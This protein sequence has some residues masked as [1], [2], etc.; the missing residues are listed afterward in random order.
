M[1]FP[2]K[3]FHGKIKGKDI[4]DFTKGL[5]YN[6]ESTY[7]RILHIKNKLG[8]YELDGAKFYHPFWE[9]IFEQSFDTKLKREGVYYVKE[10]NQFLTTKEFKKWCTK[11]NIEPSD[12]LDLETMFDGLNGGGTWNYSNQNTSKIKLVLNSTDN[13]YSE[14]NIAKGLE[15]I[16]DYILAKDKKLEKVDYEFY[17]GEDLKKL[18]ALDEATIRKFTL[19]TEEDKLLFYKDLAIN[20]KKEKKQVLT[21]KDRETEYLKDYVKAIDGCKHILGVLRKCDLHIKEFGSVQEEYKEI[22]ERWNSNRHNLIKVATGLPVDAKIVKDMINGTIY[23]KNP[24][25]DEGSPDWD[26]VDMTN[27]SHVRA[28]L[29]IKPNN[30]MQ[31][32][33]A[34]IVYDLDML[35][36]K[37][38]LTKLQQKVL[39]RLRDGKSQV[40]IA[41]EL[42]VSRQMINKHIDFIVAKVLKEVNKQLKNY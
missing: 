36:K 35:V 11:N 13:I 22:Y 37:S 33:L 21:S 1:A 10:L 23:F 24:L 2:T 5:D 4:N 27:P 6:I 40:Q 20:Y 9:E 30:N 12:Y 39:D 29:Y 14:S 15:K 32:D 16:A 28:L 41:K 7:D 31:Q 18:E 25:R 26:L 38:R 34:C 8:E 42:G 19:A 3:N 17:T